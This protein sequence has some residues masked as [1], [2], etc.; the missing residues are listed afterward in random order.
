MQASLNL[1]PKRARFLERAAHPPCTTAEEIV[2][3]VFHSRVIQAQTAAKDIL[4]FFNKKVEAVRKATGQG[5]AVTFLSLATSTLNVFQPYTEAGVAKVITA[6]PSS[7]ANLT[8]FQL[9]S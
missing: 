4:D 6:A 3:L 8:R 1:P 5:H 9:T 7:R 2:K